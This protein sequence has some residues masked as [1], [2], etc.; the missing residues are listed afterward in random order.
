MSVVY[1]SSQEGKREND[2]RWGGERVMMKKEERGKES[3]G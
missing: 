3:R 2:E 1:G